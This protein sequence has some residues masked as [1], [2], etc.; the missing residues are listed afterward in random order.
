MTRA[1]WK[2]VLRLGSQKVPVTFYSAVIDRVVHFRLLHD[3]DKEPVEQRIIRKS[4]GEE[5]PAEERRKAFPV[6]RDTLVILQPQE[7]EGLEPADSRDIEILRFVPRVG[8]GDQWFDRPYFLGPDRDADDYFALAAAL[9]ASEC[10]G[11][12]RWVMR[13][14][15]QLGA[16]MADNGYLYV[17][18]LHRAEQILRVDAGQLPASKAPSEKEL[19][20]AQQLVE[21]VS[22]EFDPRAWHDEHHERVCELIEAK[23]KGKKVAT[24]T[25]KRKTETSDLAAALQRSLKSGSKEKR[26]GRERH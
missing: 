12:V 16:L 2:G 13:D 20:L 23:A 24:K 26:V 22:G 7:L 6:D 9:Q 8:L 25:G 11:I 17:I 4:D 5:V 1:L 14:K 18:T 15:R 10:A 21:S 3:K 19:A